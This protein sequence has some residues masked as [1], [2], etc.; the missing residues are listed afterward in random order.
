MITCT[1][2]SERDIEPQHDEDEVV[3][4]VMKKKRR[5]VVDDNSFYKGKRHPRQEAKI[6][7]DASYVAT[8]VEYVWDVVTRGGGWGVERAMGRPHGR[9]FCMV[10]RCLPWP[11]S[12]CFLKGAL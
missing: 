4:V 6:K 7:E 8:W 1:L 5:R 2:L 9:P 10:G 12:F 11:P 3:V